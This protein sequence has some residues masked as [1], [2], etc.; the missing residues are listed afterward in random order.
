MSENVKSGGGTTEAGRGETPVRSLVHRT[1]LGLTVLILVLCGGVYYVTTTFEEVSALLSQ[2]LPPEWFPRLLIWTIVLLSLFL[3]F[4]HLS[5]KGESGEIDKDRSQRIKPMAVV[6][7][8]LLALV[9]AS[10]P[11]F[12]TLVA[13]VL[14]CVLLPLLWGER[15]AKVLVPYIVLF[16]AAV[17]FLFTKVLKVYFEPGAFGLFG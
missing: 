6:T 2:N 4:E 11:L 13:M 16:P 5:R 1:D 8:I 12:G 14:G 9:V 10:I 7:A 15:R 3:P 17:A